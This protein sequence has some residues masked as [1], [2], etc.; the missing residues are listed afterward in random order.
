MKV[1]WTLLQSNRYPSRYKN[2]LLQVLQVAATL[3]SLFFIY[4]VVS[5]QD[6]DWKLLIP[7]A[8]NV[9]IALVVLLLMPVNWGLEALRWQ[10]AVPEEN[11]SLK[12]AANRVLIGLAL[13][14][15]VPLTLGDAGGRLIGVQNVK[16]AIAG[17]VQV[18]VVSLVITLGF[19]GLSL[20]YYFN[21]APGHLLPILALVF[22]SLVLFPF[23][24]TQKN[25]RLLLQYS[26]LRYSVFTFQLF[27]LLYSYLPELSPVS[28]VMGVGWIFLFRSVI[29]SLFGNFGVREASALIFFESL[30]VSPALVLAPCLLI[31]L[32]NTVLPSLMGAFRLSQLNIKIAR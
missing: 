15:W 18:R 14:W 2:R 20:L 27:L 5:G 29:P 11:L 7:A 16:K 12:E 10:V 32:I 25:L 30:E 26:V 3:I 24:I 8:D 19:G 31:W 6:I 23:F 9:W 28:L 4:Y 21:Y 22:L 13:S 17:L 1:P